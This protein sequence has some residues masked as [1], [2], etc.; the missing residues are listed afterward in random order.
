M[1]QTEDPNLLRVLQVMEQLNFG[2]MK[3]KRSQLQKH[4][5]QNQDN[6]LFL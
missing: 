3:I 4:I 2:K 6:W 5:N 1:Q